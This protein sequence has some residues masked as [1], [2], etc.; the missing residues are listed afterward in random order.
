M[1]KRKPVAR[2]I[3]N[4]LKQKEVLNSRTEKKRRTLA[5]RKTVTLKLEE[6]SGKL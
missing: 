2:N 3:W 5:R 1:Y 4:R 6:G